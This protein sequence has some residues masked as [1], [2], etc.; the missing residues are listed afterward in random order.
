MTAPRGERWDP[1]ARGVVR[2]PSGRLVGGR[3]L[4]DAEPSGRRP[5]LAAH[6]L[7]AAP[8]TAIWQQRWLGW[9]DF[10]LLGDRGAVR[11]VLSKAWERAADERV[12]I[13]CTGGHRRTGTALACLA[14]LDGGAGSR[15]GRLRPSSRRPTRQ[16]NAVAATLRGQFP[17]L[18]TGRRTGTAR[19]T[20]G[21]GAPL[22]GRPKPMIL[23]ERPD[24]PERFGGDQL[25]TG[26]FGGAWLE[27]TRWSN[28]GRLAARHLQ[29]PKSL[30]TQS[31]TT[32][33]LWCRES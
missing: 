1:S 20:R 5:T 3:R 13:A 29:G 23:L 2:F 19:A 18:K 7:A 16:R 9:P 32:S 24:G 10:A 11:R 12:E 31:W 6:L 15:G 26:S 4:R 14:A 8:P 28:R 22:V 27:L 21:A 17:R 33:S 30:M 25:P